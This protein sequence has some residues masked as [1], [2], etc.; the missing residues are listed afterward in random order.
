LL[1]HS[2]GLFW[3]RDEVEWSPG[4]GN[5]GAFR[6]LGRIGSNKQSIRV[7]DFRTQ[8]GI[9]ILYGNHG[10]H[11]VGLTRK[12]SLGARLKQHTNDLHHDSWDRFSW[13]GF[14]RLLKKTDSAGLSTLG[15]MPKLKAIAPDKVIGD[16]EALLIKAMAVRNT[17]QMTFHNADAWTQI[18]KDEIE[19][20]LDKLGP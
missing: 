15:S 14:K 8:I 3:R 4:K 2:F 12:Q 19:Y 17:A 18:K 5:K 16:I 20:F 13:F 11:Y 10:P 9:Y 7:V 1:I 6:L